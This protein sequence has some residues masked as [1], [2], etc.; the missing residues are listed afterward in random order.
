MVASNTNGNCT[1][2][3]LQ[4]GAGNVAFNGSCQASI[5]Y[6]YPTNGLTV[7]VVSS[8]ASVDVKNYP[9]TD[10]SAP[11]PASAVNDT[12][13]AA[14]S[15]VTNLL[16]MAND[17]G[18]GISVTNV[19]QPALG[20]VAIGGGGASVDYTGAG[21]GSTSFTYTITASDAST[22]TATVN[23]TVT[24]NTA[25]TLSVAQPS[26]Q[27]GQ[28]LASPVAITYTLSDPDNVV[29]A[30]FSLD[31]DTNSGNG[32]GSAITCTGG[33]GQGNEGTNVTCTWDASAIATGG[34][35][36]YVY[37]T[38]N[39]GVNPA[40]GAYSGS[41]T[42]A[43]TPPFAD[44]T[45]DFAGAAD[46]ATAT[47]TNG[48]SQSGDGSQTACVFTAQNTT[49]SNG[50]GMTVGNPQP[51]AYFE[52]STGGNP[53]CGSYNGGDSFW[54]ESGD[55]DASSYSFTLSFDWDY[56]S[57]NSGGGNDR[58]LAVYYRNGTGGTWTKLQDIAT[59]ALGATSSWQSTGAIN[60]SSVLNQAGSRVRIQV[61]SASTDWAQ[62][63]AIDNIT[64]NGTP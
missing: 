8:Q 31:T 60:L 41:I 54:M 9:I 29:T 39:D 19:T 15:G 40:V 26:G 11:T 38:A 16:V 58:T 20:S 12:M 62:D 27:T 64:I 46:A 47:F 36:Y 30:S 56:E 61:T 53:T 37:A 59:Q 24:A 25:P 5:A 14:A 57:N 33:T 48:W 22:S 52:S 63:I 18:S 34:N 43:S 3:T 51:Y 13:S 21:A 44:Y 1:D 42:F 4:T 7:D 55:L 23:L 28:A 32:T 10:S 6:N 2:L 17:S 50:T 49:V 35:T 45:I